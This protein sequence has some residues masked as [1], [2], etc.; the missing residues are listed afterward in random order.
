MRLA[1]SKTQ[2]LPENFIVAFEGVLQKGERMDKS[3]FII[4]LTK[5]IVMTIL[6]KNVPLKYCG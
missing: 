2:K 5:I 6:I 4:K 3:E 1:I